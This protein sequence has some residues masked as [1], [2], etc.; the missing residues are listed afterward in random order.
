MN[1]LAVRLIDRITAALLES[2]VDLHPESVVKYRRPRAILPRDCP[3]L[4]IWLQN[5]DL[6][7]L[8]TGSFHFVNRIGASWHEEAIEQVSQLDDDPSV[9]ISLLQNIEKIERRM[10]KLCHQGAKVE[11]GWPKEAWELRPGGTEYLGINEALT[12]GYAV[13]ITVRTRETA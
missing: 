4:C 8:D 11:T 5:K 2:R 12:E 6:E 7:N 10:M 3:L 13:G 1:P 9:P